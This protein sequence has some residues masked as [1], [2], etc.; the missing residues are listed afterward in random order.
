MTPS[1]FVFLNQWPLTPSGKVDRRSLPAPDGLG[2]SPETEFVAP[3]DAVEEQLVQIWSDVLGTGPISVR[4]N[5]FDLGGHSLLAVRLMARIERTFNVKLSLATLFQQ[6]T[7]EQLA[8]LLRLHQR[9][10]TWSC[11][12][13]VQPHGSRPPFFCVHPVGGNVVCYAD[14]ARDSAST[15][16]STVFRPGDCIGKTRRIQ[17]SRTWRLITWRRC[18][19]SSR[20][21]L[22]IW[23]AGLWEGPWLLKWPG[24]CASRAATLVFSPF[25]TRAPGMDGES[26]EVDETLLMLH[27]AEDRGLPLPEVINAAL[28]MQQLPAGERLGYLLEQVRKANILG[29]DVPMERVH[30][31]AHVFMTNLVAVRKYNPPVYPGPATLFRASDGPPADPPVPTDLGWGRLAAGGV[32]IIDV[33]GDHASM[34]KEPDVR[35]LAERLTECLSHTA[36]TP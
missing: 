29:T 13:P 33:P 30:Q 16:R 25:L 1:A 27:F 21:A 24:S 10:S 4:H 3:R 18:E 17:Q 5:F 31:L 12:V 7:V 2:G 26:E 22:T 19:T 9:C 28:H 14:L 11:L 15:S 35:V 34:V 23:A 6:G 8:N 32:K 36:E 20:T